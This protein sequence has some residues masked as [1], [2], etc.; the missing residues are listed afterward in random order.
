MLCEL[1][2]VAIIG[3]DVKH[4]NFYWKKGMRYMCIGG[5]RVVIFGCG[6]HARSVVN[7]L[8]E[9]SQNLEIVLVDD[10]ANDNE[11][12]LDCQVERYYELD[13]NDGYIV[14]VGDNNARKGIYDSLANKSIG[15]CIAVVSPHSRLGVEAQIGKGTFIAS[16]VFVGPEAKIGYNSILNTG[17][18]LEHEV[19]I[20]NHTHIAP[21]AI[22]CGRS[23]IGNNV[24][25]GAG[26]VIIDKI[27]VCDNV[28]IGAGAVVVKD[29][30]IPGTYVGVPA[31]KVK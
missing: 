24:F 4:W 1:Y 11:V 9:I 5:N 21:G 30:L 28:V 20:G 19:Q 16:N 18:V 6:G 7:I 25:C 22:V 14:A 17:S 27:H 13:E 3:Q 15:H 8:R 2:Y 31:K 12:I 10:N 29:I 26:S 23:T